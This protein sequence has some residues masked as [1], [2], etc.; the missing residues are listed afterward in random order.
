[1]SMTLGSVI[2]ASTYIGTVS[3]HAVAME[4]SPFPFPPL[5]ELV[6]CRRD[7]HD[8]KMFV[9]IASGMRFQTFCQALLLTETAAVEERKVRQ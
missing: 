4:W 7:A 1:M 5:V 9:S 2:D 6:E 8:G 3:Q